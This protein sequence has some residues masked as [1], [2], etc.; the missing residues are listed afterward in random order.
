MRLWLI[1]L[2][3]LSLISLGSTEMPASYYAALEKIPNLEIICVKNYQAGASIT[4]SYTNFEYVDKETQIISRI[5]N[6]T[7]D[8]KSRAILEAEISSNV[9]GRAHLAWQ[10]LDPEADRR[11]R[12]PFIS[13]NRED[14]IGVFSINKFIQLWSNS[15]A[16]NA[17]S[18]NWLTCP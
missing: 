17:T 16:E 9:I 1:F 14:L 18:L 8:C 3:A 2:I 13:L 4:E 15:T 11:G 10:S 5:Y 6:S 7:D 12:H